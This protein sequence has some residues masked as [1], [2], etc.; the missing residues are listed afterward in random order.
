MGG[1]STKIISK[2]Q[3]FE[4]ALNCEDLKTALNNEDLQLR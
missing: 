4:S 1:K 2:Q 3:R